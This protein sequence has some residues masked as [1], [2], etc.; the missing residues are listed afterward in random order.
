VKR[1]LERRVVWQAAAL[2]L[3]YPDEAQA[4]RLDL[5][6]RA[7][8]KLDDRYRAPL[9]ECIAYLRGRPVVT[10]AADYV[11]TFDWRR[12]RTMFLTYYTAGDTRNRGQALLAIA[13]VYRAADAT[14]PTD[15][16]PDHLTVM[17][18]FAATVDE[19]TGYE[20]LV[21]HRTAL[22]L[23]QAGLVQAESP[24]AAVV[25]AVAA[26]LPPT[27]PTATR[28]VAAAGPPVESVGL[29]PYPV[30]AR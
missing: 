26:T 25:G 7:V 14:P 12:R 28:R 8:A 15:E 11:E 9:T 17:L 5:V 30:S 23:L 27:D 29:E 18:E 3:A 20:L 21:A 13:Q 22:D 16:L 1:D 24:Y 2:L 19:R 4:A 6:E 10:A